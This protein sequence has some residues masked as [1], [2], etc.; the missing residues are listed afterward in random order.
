VDGNLTLS[1]GQARRIDRHSAFVRSMANG[2][3]YWSSI[4]SG[5]IEVLFY[6]DRDLDLHCVVSSK[7]LLVQAFPPAPLQLW[8]IFPCGYHVHSNS[9]SQHPFHRP[10]Q[11]TESSRRTPSKTAG[12]AR[13]TRTNATRTRNGGNPPS[14]QPIRLSP[15]SSG[16]SQEIERACRACDTALRTVPPIS[17]TDA[18]LP[19][20]L[21]KYRRAILLVPLPMGIASYV[22]LCV[23]S[24]RLLIPKMVWLSTL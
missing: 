9:K 19:S 12:E 24:L 6:W 4:V 21:L 14:G 18:E 11:V 5:L 1:L 15:P 23:T 3:C 17:S 13:K 7:H 20:G 16:H 22:A 8:L 10:S 2:D